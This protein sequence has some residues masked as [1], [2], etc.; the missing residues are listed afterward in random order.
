M[1]VCVYLLLSL[2]V[3]QVV[4]RRSIIFIII[5]DYKKLLNDIR[6]VTPFKEG[7]YKI[8]SVHDGDR[9]KMSTPVSPKPPNSLEQVSGW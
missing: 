2:P 3:S 9:G 4:G 7:T 5:V 1:Y 8:L 6:S